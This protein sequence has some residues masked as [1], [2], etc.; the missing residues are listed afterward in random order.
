MGT[1]TSTHTAGAIQPCRSSSFQGA[2]YFMGPM[3]ENT[4]S[5]RPSSGTRVAVSPRRRR[6]WISAV[7][8]E[9]GA[10]SRWTSS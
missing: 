5:S 9:T 6:D 7:T 4:S 8:R 2:S 1:R 10:G 3:S